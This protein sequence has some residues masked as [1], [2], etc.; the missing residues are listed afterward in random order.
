M[1]GNLSE[2]D[3]LDEFEYSQGDEKF[4]KQH[5]NQTFANKPYDEAHEISQD[6]S[7]AESFDAR[8]KVCN[9]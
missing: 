9:C 5:R 6:L 7:V 3:D 2:D 1:S 4:S 8:D